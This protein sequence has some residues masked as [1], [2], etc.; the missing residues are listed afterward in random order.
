MADTALDE[1]SLKNAVVRRA[2]EL[3]GHVRP[4][5]V[6][7]EIRQA[8]VAP[9]CHVFRATWGTG[10]NQGALTGLLQA[11]E[12]PDTFPAQ[13]LGKLFQG[14]MEAEGTLP[15]PEEVASVSAFL[16]DAGRIHTPILTGEDRS[17]LVSR[18][19]WQP[20]VQL[21]TRIQVAGQP[22]VAFWWVGPGGPS[23]VSF[24]LTDAGT[25]RSEEKFMR[26]FL[27]G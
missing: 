19:E 6:T 9:G 20:H 15:P 22:G 10:R 14:W 18:P 17:R 2:A 16:Y 13:A 5:D 1:T 25:I 24:Y 23:E 8:E 11:G 7:L 26:D 21:P 27:Q 4:G 3:G 12:P